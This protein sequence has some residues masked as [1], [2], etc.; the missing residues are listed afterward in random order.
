MWVSVSTDLVVDARR[1]LN[2]IG[3]LQYESVRLHDLRSLRLK[4]DQKL[5]DV[6]G[7]DK[8]ILFCTYD[9]LISGSKVSK[10]KPKKQLGNRVMV[11]DGVMEILADPEDGDDDDVAP[12]DEFGACRLH[13]QQHGQD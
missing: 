5:N 6:P 2:D 7:L 13:R 3:A 12:A 10:A 4:T 1:D 11:T 8:G 9:L